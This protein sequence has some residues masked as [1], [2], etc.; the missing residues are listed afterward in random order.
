MKSPTARRMS[1]EQFMG[2]V[3]EREATEPDIAGRHA[4][5][6]LMTL[7]EAVGEEFLDASVELP[8]EFG[9]LY[10]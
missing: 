3:A 8:P 9:V 4:R 6:V 10:R 7:R 1:L 2:A 5:A